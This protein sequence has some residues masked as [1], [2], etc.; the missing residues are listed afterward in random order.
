M[1]ILHYFLGFPPYRTGGL[2][3]YVMD[4][5]EEQSKS[6]NQVIGMWPGEQRLCTKKIYVKI[7][8]KD[9][10]II[11]AELINPLPVPLD[12]GI[13][14][15]SAYSQRVEKNYYIRILKSLNPNVIHVHTLMGIHKEFFAACQELNIKTIFTSHDYF[16]LC[17]KTTFMKNHILCKDHKDC[18]NCI[19]CNV[20][21]LSLKKIML[22]QSKLY[23]WIK[24]TTI[25]KRIR[26][27][28]RINDTKNYSN[29]VNISPDEYEKKLEDFRDLNRYYKNILESID[30]IHF[31]STIAQD[32][33]LQ[34][35]E[36]QNFELL[37]ISNKSIQV[38]SNQRKERN[39]EDVITL[40][41]LGPNKHYKGI[42]TLLEAMAAKKNKNNLV[43]KLYT[44]V[45]DL[46]EG[47]TI[48]QIGYSHNQLKDIFSDSD[49][50]IVPS[51]WNETF[52]FNVIEA[53]CHKVPVIASHR[54]G[55]K[56]II[57]NGGII[58]NADKVEELTKILDELS[59]KQITE[60]YKAIPEVEGWSSFVKR[61]NAIY[62]KLNL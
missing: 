58:Y 35:I 20:N 4:L 15:P 30:L 48:K 25:M 44:M 59:H 34:H 57:G 32:I 62:Y 23:R 17:F 37:P 3:K 41:Y 16:G 6:G 12:G 61:N 27:K 8:K 11:S 50:V 29:K 2:T 36:P 45:D 55:A 46:P 39:V 31:N 42:N 51:I 14:S 26:Y 18:R 60:M 47:V 21:A 33:Y 56:D 38:N 1:K 13:C 10:G 49:I 9:E 22:L 7:R 52:G 28:H 53:L 54:V 24:D 43:L 40:T 5:M 19:E